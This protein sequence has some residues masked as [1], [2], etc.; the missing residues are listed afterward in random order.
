[1]RA[2][3]GGLVGGAIGA[4]V[5][6]V[7]VVLTGYEVGWIAWGVGGLVGFG[8]A[9]GNADGG[10]SSTA[11]GV[12]AV[13][14]AALAIVAGKYAGIV[15]T[16][17]S[18]DEIVGMFV[19]RF[20]DEEYVV[21]YVA[22]EVVAEYVQEG[23]QVDWP[24]GSDPSQASS[25]ADYPVDV[26]AEAEARWGMRSEED[27]AAYRDSLEAQT[28]ESVQEN[29][30]EIRSAVAGGGLMGSF[31]PMDVLFFGLAMVTAFGIGSGAKKTSEQ[32]AEEYAEAAQLAMLRV[33]LADG[34]IDEEEVQTV[35][36]VYRQITGDDVSAEVIRAKAAIAQSQGRDLQAA[37]R[38]L[39]LYL[40][41]QAKVAV[42][43]AAVAVAAADG[44]F[45]DEEK[46]LVSGIAEALG[47][48]ED[49]LRE[50]V[51]RSSGSPP[52]SA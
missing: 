4:A 48:T 46:V 31:A 16:M 3:V 38:D 32:L 37:L 1:M 11:A 13:V 41:D 18:D 51:L 44:H 8:V 27:R 42:L 49:Q 34:H 43:Q 14:I 40:T 12:L 6:A 30:P 29:M 23:R 15:T 39:A 19:D 24:A 36:A 22:D 28:V 10:R 52:A 45:E 9:K 21:S 50:M 17:P 5:W 35:C 25:R 47:L 2:V 33:M 26:W 7:V 20:D